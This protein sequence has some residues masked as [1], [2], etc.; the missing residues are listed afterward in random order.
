MSGRLGVGLKAADPSLSGFFGLSG[1][2]GA[3]PRDRGFFLL[4]DFG[5]DFGDQGRITRAV[6]HEVNRLAVRQNVHLIVDNEVRERHHGGSVLTGPARERRG[7]SN[8]DLGCEREGGADRMMTAEGWARV[9]GWEPAQ[10]PD[11]FARHLPVKTLDILIGQ[12]VVEVRR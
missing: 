3:A 11:D 9:F 12:G 4:G 6:E 1:G 2:L 8:R 5:L 10:R 7:I